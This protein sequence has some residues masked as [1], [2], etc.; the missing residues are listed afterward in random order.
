MLIYEG[1]LLW[2]KAYLGSAPPDSPYASPILHSLND[3]PP[4][5]IQ[6]GT[7]EMLLDDSLQL[8]QKAQAEGVEVKIE[9]Y[10]GYFHVFNA[11][12]KVLPKAIVANKNA[13]KFIA[14]KLNINVWKNFM[15]PTVHYLAV[16]L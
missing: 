13:G 3:F 16:H 15:Q 8:A 5:F 2:S 12:W 7:E 9:I 14:Q 11:F 10:S 4:L 6:V 1:F